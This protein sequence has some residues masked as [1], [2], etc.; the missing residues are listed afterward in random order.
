MVCRD[1]GHPID[2][3]FDVAAYALLPPEIGSKLSRGS[4]GDLESVA[5]SNNAQCIL[6]AVANDRFLR[7]ALG[8][9]VA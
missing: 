3:K 6:A 4:M 8:K 5:H 1:C 7:D 2:S 9:L